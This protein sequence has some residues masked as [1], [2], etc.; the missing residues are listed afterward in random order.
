VWSRASARDVF[1]K[2]CSQ[3]NAAVDWTAELTALAIQGLKDTAIAFLTSVVAGDV[4]GAYERHVGDGFRHHNPYFP[5]DAE[6]LKKGMEED[7][8]RHPGKRLDVQVAVQDGD[9]VVVHSRLRRTIDDHG[10]ALVHIFRFEQGRI[11]EAWD[12]VQSVPEDIVNENGM[13]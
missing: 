12:I 6:S 4:R 10:F 3:L 5:G 13:F 2:G 1:W 9:Y 7:E 11:A 8:A